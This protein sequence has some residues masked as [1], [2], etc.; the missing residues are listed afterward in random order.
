MCPSVC[1]LVYN[2]SAIGHCNLASPPGQDT[3]PLHEVSNV[4]HA[5]CH[6]H[7]NQ[8]AWGLSAMIHTLHAIFTEIIQF[9]NGV[10]SVLKVH[11]IGQKS[12]EDHGANNTLLGYNERVQS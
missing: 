6:I 5:I 4:P 12:P 11:I 9:L 7:S 3:K 8:S 2:D 1:V 10:S